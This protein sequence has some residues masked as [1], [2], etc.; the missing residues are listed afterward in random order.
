MGTFFSRLLHQ[1]AVQHGPLILM[2]H[3]IVPGKGVP[4]WPWAV[5]IRRFRDQLD[6]LEA[7]EYS[8]TTVHDLLTQP[9]AFA[10]RRTVALSF[11]DGYANNLDAFEALRERGM[12]ASW[13]VVAGSIGALPA[14]Q[15]ANHAMGRMLNK[16]ELR[17]MH[18]CGMEI[19]SHSMS[20]VRLSGLDDSRLRWEL[21]ESK[22]VLESCLGQTVSSFAYPYGTWDTRCARAAEDAG[23]AG[24]CTTRSGWAMR[25]GHPFTLRRLTVFNHDTAATLAR[26]LAYAATDVRWRTLARQRLDMILRNR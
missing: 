15:E 7:E 4:Q 8:T 21:A 13:Y 9:D 10:R 25:D 12:R 1:R 18:A 26:K 23:Y 22:A 19:G 24:A 16:T 11:D 20:H 2:Y 5:S 17:E 6:F 3:A 14:W